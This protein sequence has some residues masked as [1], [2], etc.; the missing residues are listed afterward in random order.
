M[1]GIAEEIADPERIADYLQSQ[2]ERNPR[3]F[4]A[5]LRSE[6]ISSK[7]SREDLVR[8]APHRPMVTIHA[9]HDAA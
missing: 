1:T 5:I 3:M 2:L 6:G 7:P 9:I 8:L 4:G